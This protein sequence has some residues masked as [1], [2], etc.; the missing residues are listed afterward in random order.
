MHNYLPKYFTFIDKFNKEFLK[1]L[2]KKV[3]IIY[4][5][6]SDKIDLKIVQKLK[7]F[8]KS[9]KR[10]LFIANNIKIAKRL[11]CDGVYISAYNKQ[12]LRYDIGQKKKFKIIGSA[13]SLNEILTKEKQG[14]DLIFLSPLFYNKKNKRSLGISKFNLLSYK[15]KIKIIALG[16]INNTNIKKLKMIKNSGFAAISFFRNKI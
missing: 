7:F 8:C 12:L 3:A 2:N 10:K 5:N 14:V 9:S 6:N 1:K 15:S 16:G 11:D 4:R 13:H